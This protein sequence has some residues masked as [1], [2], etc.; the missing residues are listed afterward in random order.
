MEARSLTT[1]IRCVSSS[2]I[3]VANHKGRGASF[4][5]GTSGASSGP[6]PASSPR[7]FLR[8][9]TTKFPCE[10]KGVRPGKDMIALL[11]PALRFTIDMCAFTVLG[12][13]W[14]KIEGGAVRIAIRTF[15]TVRRSYLFG[16]G[17]TVG[18]EV[19][20]N[21]LE[22]VGKGDTDGHKPSAHV[23]LSRGILQLGS[24]AA[25]IWSATVPAHP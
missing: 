11:G 19:V 15:L 23:T 3:M 13:F 5:S 8:L 20:R 7:L 25:K 6:S 14:P 9:L 10:T 17:P 2:K 4:G 24:D 1:R 18:I 22:E 16:T 21:L 12:D